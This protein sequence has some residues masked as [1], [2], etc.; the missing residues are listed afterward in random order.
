MK[1]CYFTCASGAGLASV[2]L[3][4][5]SCSVVENRTTTSCDSSSSP[6]PFTNTIVYDHSSSCGSRPLFSPHLRKSALQRAALIVAAPPHEQMFMRGWSTYFIE[7]LA[8]QNCRECSYHGCGR[9]V[10]SVVTAL[11]MIRVENLQFPIWREFSC[12]MRGPH[13]SFHFDDNCLAMSMSEQW[14]NAICYKSHM[15]LWQWIDREH[16]ERKTACIHMVAV[17]LPLTGDIGFFRA[18]HTGLIS[19]PGL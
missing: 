10:V 4:P 14:S 5:L 15:V 2:G 18:K 9:E 7:Y 19:S 1:T 8:T 13:C 11:E 16:H 6:N 3:K 17:R 12:Q